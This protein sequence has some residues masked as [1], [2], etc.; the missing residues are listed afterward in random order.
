[1][2]QL[3]LPFD[4]LVDAALHLEAVEHERDS[5]GDGEGSKN[6]NQRRGPFQKNKPWNKK[7]KTGG[8]AVQAQPQIQ[9]QPSGT[10]PPRKCFNCGSPD[11]FIREC[12][13]PLYCTFCK[14]EGHRISTCPIAP[15]SA[16]PGKLN[17]A[18]APASS[19]RPRGTHP[20]V[21]EGSILFHGRSC[22]VLFDTGASHSFVSKELVDALS[23][24]VT[25]LVS[26]LRIVNPIG[27][28]TTL[29]LLCVDINIDL[30]GFS[31]R[32]NLHVMEYLGFDM[33]LAWIGSFSTTPKLFVRSGYYSF[34]TLIRPLR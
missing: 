30:C 17:A 2:L 10:R 26:S 12:P 25:C 32:A 15:A 6:P 8:F 5:D 28:S 18:K 4:E 19:A 14:K 16:K 34:I 13:K 21:L 33:I 11:H 3:K 31:F 22:R 7:K 1:M 23:L 24:D 29:S 20:S 9:S 27:G